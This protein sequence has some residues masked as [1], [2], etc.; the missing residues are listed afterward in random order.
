MSGGS[1]LHGRE[2]AVVGMAGRF[3]GASDLEQVWRNLEARPTGG[4]PRS[5]TSGWGC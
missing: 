4:Q 2:I 5:R 1:E 3:P